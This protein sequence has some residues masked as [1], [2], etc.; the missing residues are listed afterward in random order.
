MS[1]KLVAPFYV[2]CIPFILLPYFYNAL[3]CQSMALCVDKLSL[4]FLLHAGFL[5][6]PVMLRMRV[7]TRGKDFL[8]NFEDLI[9]NDCAALS[10]QD[11]FFLCLCEQLILIFTHNDFLVTL[12][13][14]SSAKCENKPTMIK[15]KKMGGFVCFLVI[16]RQ[17]FFFSWYSSFSPVTDNLKFFNFFSH[18]LE[19]LLGGK[20]QG[21]KF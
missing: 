6:H 14:E 20:W 7:K 2:V 9:V 3:Q 11:S 15:Q 12:S 18:S 5:L 4:W 10:T 8:N 1:H 21:P 19:Y 13:P 17:K 16:H